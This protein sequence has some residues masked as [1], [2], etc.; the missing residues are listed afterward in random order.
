MGG[1]G[2][3]GVGGGGRGRFVR[4]VLTAMRSELNGSGGEEMKAMKGFFKDD[5]DF[6]VWNTAY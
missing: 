3:G 2:G 6:A 1:A 4:Y 5:A